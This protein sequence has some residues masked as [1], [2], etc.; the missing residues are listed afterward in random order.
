MI[1]RQYHFLILYYLTCNVV[2]AECNGYGNNK[3]PLP[4]RQSYKINDILFEPT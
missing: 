1:S 3:F 2:L 4:E